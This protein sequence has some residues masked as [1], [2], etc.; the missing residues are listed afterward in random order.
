MRRDR[1]ASTSLLIRDDADKFFP[2]LSVASSCVFAPTR[3]RLAA[4]TSF[5]GPLETLAATSGA[6]SAREF[7]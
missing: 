4:L 3:A 2:I 5:T 7:S 6:F 1:S